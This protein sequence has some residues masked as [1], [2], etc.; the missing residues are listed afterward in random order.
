MEKTFTEDLCKTATGN[1]SVDVLLSS[2]N[3]LK[4]KQFNFFI[5]FVILNKFCPIQMKGG[6][7][8]SIIDSKIDYEMENE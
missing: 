5:Y 3:V 8:W 6:K 7:I 1:K 4:L 2:Q